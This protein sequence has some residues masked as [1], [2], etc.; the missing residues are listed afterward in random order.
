MRAGETAPLLQSRRQAGSWLSAVMF[1]VAAIAAFALCVLA[2]TA[3]IPRTTVLLE[4]KLATATAARAQSQLDR[5]QQLADIEVAPSDL[6]PEVL[7]SK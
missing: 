6:G 3:Q 2:V 5:A 4:A 1:A 7:N